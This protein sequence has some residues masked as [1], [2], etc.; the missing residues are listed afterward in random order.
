MDNGMLSATTYDALR[1]R[2]PMQGADEVLERHGPPDWVVDM[3]SH[4]FDA[5]AVVTAGEMWLTREE[6]TQHLRKGDCFQIPAG[7]LHSERFGPEGA[8]Y[9]VARRTPR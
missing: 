3:H 2:S 5:D 1:A 8:T 6:G 7:M 4:P 9:R